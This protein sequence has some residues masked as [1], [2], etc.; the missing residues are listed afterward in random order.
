VGWVGR[1]GVVFC[2]EAMGQRDRALLPSHVC[3]ACCLLI[4]SLGHLNSFFGGNAR[5]EG[6]YCVLIKNNARSVY[7]SDDIANIVVSR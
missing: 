7:S 5:V 6:E 2:R 4:L 1:V 3:Q